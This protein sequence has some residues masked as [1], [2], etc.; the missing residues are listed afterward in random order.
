MLFVFAGAL[1]YLVAQ[2]LLRKHVAKVRRAKM[3][4]PNKHTT[5]GLILFCFV[6]V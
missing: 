6:K 2:H 5:G 4:H 1:E 3:A